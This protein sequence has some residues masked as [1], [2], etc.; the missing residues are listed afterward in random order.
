M[1]QK[2]MNRVADMKWALLALL[3]GAPIPV[4]LLIWLFVGHR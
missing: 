4:V 2:T 1:L 3:L